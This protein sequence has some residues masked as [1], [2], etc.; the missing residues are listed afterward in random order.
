MKITT[1]LFDFS[2]VLIHAKDKTVTSLNGFYRELIKHP[3]Y[4]FFAH[5]K[6]N[7]E[8]LDI[9]KSL[10]KKYKLYIFTNE[11]I[12]NEP[13]IRPDL[14]SIFDG[15]YSAEE[16]GMSKKEPLT[17]TYLADTIK[18]KPSDILFIDDTKVNIDAATF[19]GFQTH[20]YHTNKELLELIQSL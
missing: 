20:V 11:I 6:L 14:D 17:Y 15:I 16:L 13:T 9:L 12:Q 1:L 4:D 8:I 2:N 5:Y 3:S 10:K 19:A 7:H 18:E